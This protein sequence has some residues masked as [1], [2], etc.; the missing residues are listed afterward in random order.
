MLTLSRPK[1]LVY[2]N[3]RR[4]DHHFADAIWFLNKSFDVTFVGNNKYPNSVEF[5]NVNPKDYDL[6]VAY[7]SG[8][9]TFNL[10]G[11]RYDE[12]VDDIVGIPRILRTVDTHLRPAEH[13]VLSQR[14]D[15][16]LYSSPSHAKYLT[17]DSTWLPMHTN[18]DFYSL[19]K[20]SHFNYK[21]IKAA[22]G[23]EYYP[24]NFEFEQSLDR[25]ISLSFLIKFRDYRAQAAQKSFGHLPSNLGKCII[26]KAVKYAATYI[27]SRSKLSLHLQCK[28][29]DN[30]IT[31]RPLDA[32]ACGAIPLIER[33]GDSAWKDMFDAVGFNR[34]YLFDSPDDVPEL[35]ERALGEYHPNTEDVIAA[36]KNFDIQ[37]EPHRLVALALG[38]IDNWNDIASV[39]GE[40]NE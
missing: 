13:A 40:A 18:V 5:E 3:V 7:D 35:V 24:L 30:Y 31:W 10:D 12:R 19:D 39:D 11:E 20:A 14:Y 36:A 29:F 17:G 34:Y 32:M 22:L 8:S 33:G 16:I 38:Q 4:V 9:Q 23:T 28:K 27:H 25:Y 1:L 2:W 21:T 6:L 15:K 26:A 37:L